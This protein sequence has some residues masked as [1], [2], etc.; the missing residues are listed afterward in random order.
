MPTTDPVL[1]DTHALLWWRAESEQLSS[2]ARS[3]LENALIVL[4][5]PMTLWEIAMLA[6]KGRI[7]LDRSATQWSRDVLTEGDVELT[8]ID[9]RIAVLA[10]EVAPFHGDPVDRI[11]VA[12]ARLRRVPLVTKD[13]LIS[14]YATA[15]TELDVVW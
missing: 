8:L 7:V 4:V 2:T 10:A 1:I 11:L 14:A 6:G 3:R 13:R 9:E 15:S 5:S 12:T